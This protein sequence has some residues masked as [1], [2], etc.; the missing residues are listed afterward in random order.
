M[1]Q[2][3][4]IGVSLQWVLRQHITWNCDLFLVRR[5]T[6]I[7][8][9]FSKVPIGIVEYD[10]HLFVSLSTISKFYRNVE[11]MVAAPIALAT[12]D[13]FYEIQRSDE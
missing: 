1:N 7:L 6:L 3:L 8:S 11:I 9:M 12:T 2:D 5:F 4:H 10:Q 13:S